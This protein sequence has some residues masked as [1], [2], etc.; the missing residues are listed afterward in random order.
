[1]T[2]AAGSGAEWA[3]ALS[4]SLRTRAPGLSIFSGRPV[5]TEAASRPL[6]PSPSLPCP[7]PRPG[8]CRH[9]PPTM[10]LKRIHKVSG[11]RSVVGSG[12]WAGQLSRPRPALHAVASTGLASSSDPAAREG[13]AGRPSHPTPSDGAGG[14]PGAQPAL[15]PE[16]LWPAQSSFQASFL[17][18]AVVWSPR[19]CPQLGTA[20]L[21][22]HCPGMPGR[23]AGALGGPFDRGRKG[24]LPLSAGSPLPPTCPGSPLNRPSLGP[25]YQAGRRS[26]F[27]RSTSIS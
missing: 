12:R 3:S 1:M 4:R 8:G 21:E 6:A 27:V 20:A 9:P 19:A 16:V 17:G 10:A 24:S 18:S 26:L 23:G 11:R 15:R 5:I 14:G 25:T 13:P 7:R 22:G 2:A